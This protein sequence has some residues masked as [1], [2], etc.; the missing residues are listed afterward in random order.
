MVILMGCIDDG[1]IPKTL[2]CSES[3]MSNFTPI[4]EHKEC[5]SGV[6]MCNYF[7]FGGNNIS[8]IIKKES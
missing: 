2:S 4:N 3:I 6:F 8:L 1:F 7:G 5:V